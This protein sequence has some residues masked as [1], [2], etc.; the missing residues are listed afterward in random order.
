MKNGGHDLAYALSFTDI[1]NGNAGSNYM[2]RDELYR[3]HFHAA[4]GIKI[5]GLSGYWKLGAL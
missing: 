2:K 4:Q 3:F 1:A 5:W